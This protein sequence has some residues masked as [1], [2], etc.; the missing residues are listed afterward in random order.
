MTLVPLDIAL[1]LPENL[2]RQA[3]A[4]SELVSGNMAA[5]GSASYFQLGKPFPGD[6]AEHCEPHVSLFMLAVDEAEVGDVVRVVKQLAETLSGLDAEAVGYHYN[7][8]GAVEVYFA[9]SGAWR[10]LQ[11]AVITSVEPLRRGR[12]REVDPSGTRIR[13]LMDT[14]SPSRQQLLKYGY[15]EVADED[16][17]GR[18]RFNPHVTLAWPRDR[19]FRVALDGLPAPRSFSGLLTGLAVYGMSGY[20]TCTKSYGVLSLGETRIGDSFV[21]SR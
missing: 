21:E 14:E 4:C 19:D 8:Y 17:G 1:V 16:D 7:P 11:R 20:G 18:D 9:R 2:R 3:I 15:D 12:L 13:D 6:G 5:G 10:A